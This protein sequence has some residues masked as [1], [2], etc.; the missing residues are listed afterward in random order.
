M[1]FL[2]NSGFSQPFRFSNFGLTSQCF[3]CFWDFPKSIVE[4]EIIEA[5]EFDVK[6]FQNL[7][8]LGILG[9]CWKLAN[10]DFQPVFGIPGF[11]FQVRY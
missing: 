4:S 5:E 7:F 9:N 8:N 6:I 1:V 3:R 2:G 11:L 10:S